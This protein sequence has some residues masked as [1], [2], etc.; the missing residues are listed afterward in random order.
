MI[1]E[2]VI[3]SILDGFCEIVQVFFV[4]RQCRDNLVIKHFVHEISDC[5]VVHAVSHDVEAS[6]ICS[7]NKARVCSVENANFAFL[8][9]RNV[10]HNM[11]RKI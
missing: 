1:Y 7:R 4:E 10:R 3:K 9:R 8:I 2:R 11:N 6:K 5:V